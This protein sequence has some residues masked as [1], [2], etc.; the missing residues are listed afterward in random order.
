MHALILKLYGHPEFLGRNAYSLLWA[1]EMKK[2]C[3]DCWVGKIIL[4]HASPSTHLTEVLQK[5]K[6]TA[7]WG[8]W[9]ASHKAVGGESCGDRVWLILTE[10]LK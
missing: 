7:P 9:P 10:N 2:T 4:A 5:R 6:S 1:R 3:K 8:C